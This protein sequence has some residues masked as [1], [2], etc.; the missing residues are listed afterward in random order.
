MKHPLDHPALYALWQ[1][2]FARQ[3]LRPI[4]DLAALRSEA[5][6]L[7]AACGP[8]DY[9]QLFDPKGYVGIDTNAAYIERANRKHSASRGHFTV[10]DAR[11]FDPPDRRFGLVFAN[12]FLHHL[13][14]GGAR[15]A[16]ANLARL[17]APGGRLLL[18]D[19]LL[20]ETQGP[21]RWL[22]RADRGD[23]PRSQQHW[24]QLLETSYTPRRVEPYTLRLLG[25]PLWRMLFVE[26]SPRR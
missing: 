24:L 22:A 14:D 5:S 23:W 26:A 7:D 10:A 13:D 21:A 4:G 15:A 8:G 25:T 18:M 9:A 1:A 3:K 17:T 16:L 12:S 19:L 20:P 11:T 2:P 6:V